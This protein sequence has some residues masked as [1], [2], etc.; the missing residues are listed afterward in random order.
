MLKGR[1][2][3]NGYVSHVDVNPQAVES[4]LGD[5]DWSRQ[6]DSPIWIDITDGPHHIPGCKCSAFDR[7]DRKQSLRIK[8]I[9]FCLELP[10]STL[11]KEKKSSLHVWRMCAKIVLWTIGTLCHHC[12]TKIQFGCHTFPF[13]LLFLQL[14]LKKKEDCSCIYCYHVQFNDLPNNLIFLYNKF[15]CIW[16]FPSW[17]WLW[18]KVCFSI[19]SWLN[20]SQ[21][22]T[23]H[24]FQRI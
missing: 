5:R 4:F 23:D 19:V 3:V 14:I 21:P 18:S 17:I 9:D 20:G 12:S 10:G 7:F 13:N 24:F 22:T 8:V 11:W 15:R 1:V 6:P 16:T 2:K